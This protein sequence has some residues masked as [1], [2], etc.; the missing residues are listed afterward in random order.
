MRRWICGEVQRFVK[1][2]TCL[3]ASQQ[4]GEHN[5]GNACQES[6][7]QSPCS[8]ETG[9]VQ[10]TDSHGSQKRLSSQSEKYDIA[11]NA[12]KWE[13]FCKDLD[14]S[15]EDEKPVCD[16]EVDRL[17]PGEVDDVNAYQ[18]NV[19]RH[20]TRLDY[21]ECP[22]ESQPNQASDSDKEPVSFRVVACLVVL[23]SR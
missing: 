2:N 6:Q 17:N 13:K 14:D 22:C 20:A 21:K 15:S 5:A 19:T 8:D 9:E 3:V 23:R 11:K 7:D 1:T 12:E 4:T 18:S 10:A 16:A